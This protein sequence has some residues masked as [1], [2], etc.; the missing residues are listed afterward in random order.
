MKIKNI[1]I[2]L[3]LVLLPLF[4]AAQKPV[5][6]SLNWIEPV[7][8]YFGADSAMQSLAFE[9]AQYTGLP[10]EILPFSVTITDVP[11]GM[12]V[13]D[14]RFDN[15]TYIPISDEERKV[16]GEKELLSAPYLNYEVLSERGNL[17]AIAT[18]LPFG[19]NPASGKT[20]KLAS[21]S[22]EIT[23]AASPPVLKSVNTYADNS[24]L[25]TGDWYKFYLAESGVYKITF[26]DLKNLGI[27]TNGLN[28]DKI[29]IFGNGG[30]ML[31]M[32]AGVITADDLHENSISVFTATPG[33]F[34]QGDYILFYGKGPQTWIRNPLSGRLD[35]TTHLYADEACYFLTIGAENG[36]RI[37]FTE[38]P[39]NPADYFVNEYTALFHYEKDLYNLIKSG[40]KWFG[41][42][43]DFYNRTLNIPQVTF[44]DI[45]PGSNAVIRYGI[46]GRST[47]NALSFNFLVNNQVVGTSTLAKITSKYDYAFD[48]ITSA[49]FTPPAD[50]LDIQFKFNPL[51]S[52]DL[53]WLDFI[54]L[55]VQCSLKFTGG[56]MSFRD[57]KSIA[58]NR[59][60]EFS[61]SNA[62]TVTEIW[63]VTDP[64]NVFLV[65]YT[66]SGD[67]VKFNSNTTVL[68]E[69][70]ALNGTSYN[71]IRPGEKISNQNLHS[72]G[73]YDLIVITHP[74]FSSQAQ[75]LAT[76]HNDM[77]EISAIVVSLPEIYNEFSSGIQDITAIRNFM[78]MLYD[79]GRDAGYPK[80]LLLF[81]NASYD[82]KNRIP[83]N[84]NF[85][86]SFQSDNS[87]KTTASFLSDDYY[88]LLDDGEGGSNAAGMLDVA[89]GRMPV[90]TQQEAN[91]V[92][93][94]TI[95]YMANDA[96]VHGDWRNTLI[97][98]ADDEDR[99]AHLNQAEGLTDSILRNHPV[100]NTEKIYFDA[101]KQVSTPGGSRY[102]DVNRE[103]VSKVEKGALVVNYIG[104]GGEVG[105]ADERILEIAD[106]N[107]WTN[108]SRMGLFFTA[109]CEFSRFD[110]PGHTSAGELVFLNPDGGAM[111]MITTTRLAFSSNNAA[112]NLSFADTAFKSTGGNIP[113]LGDILKYTKN[114][115]G[116]GANTRHLTLFG[117][118]SIRM[119][120]P[121][122]KVITTSIND[123][124][125]GLP[126]D[127]LFATSLVKVTGEVRDAENILLTGFNGE[128]Q[129]KVLDKPSKVRTLGQD[130]LSLQTEFYVQKSILYQ[131]KASVVNGLFEFTFPVPKDIDYSFGRGKLSYYV[132]DGT[133]DG[134]G[135]SKDFTIG[136]S[137]NQPQLD[138]TGP[139]IK[140]FMNDTNFI[141]GSITNESPKLL[142]YL[143]DESGINTV[144]NGIGHDIVATINGNNY[145]S[146]VLNDY[147]IADLNS[148]QS[149]SL[150]YQYFNLPDGEHILTLKAWDV[151]NNSSEASIR[152]EVKRNIILSLDEVLAYPNPTKGP[153][154]FRFGHNQYDGRFDVDVEIYS[155]TGSLVRSL[156]PFKVLSE[157]YQSGIVS[158]DGRLDD[159]SLARG[160]LYVARLKVR[161]RNGNTTSNTAKV[162]VAR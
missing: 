111:S 34:A 32:T 53:G 126:A 94:K 57:S 65:N 87:I 20:E 99:N 155:S 37:T 11:A 49:T 98:L 145:N 138:F 8:L 85:V 102:P 43:M 26:D 71:S 157:G 79:R 136:G 9:K 22:L 13:E 103:L 117:D 105:W 146:I 113:R 72:I 119:P 14:I 133:V 159:G 106:I 24:V 150:L 124:K 143:F 130:P 109:T 120:L 70:I 97:V 1:L 46:A 73:N 154:S 6:V 78:K 2:Y 121:K 38:P 140:L 131:G 17:K 142:A 52:T 58:N 92:V 10:D 96:P 115:N 55:N 69:F 74:D 4:V 128:V 132:T 61:L 40:R 91:T 100:Y 54:T 48:L 93:E 27:N 89:V 82:V 147:Y 64:L 41:E 63:D 144:G 12:H 86:P 80:Y 139:E 18:V 21:Y 137:S 122:H 95:T 23:F 141:E 160:G 19:L 45:I 67:V 104:H 76:A 44:S 81:G 156:G 3:V 107:S 84:S 158:W 162:I 108:Y 75:T 50:M 83:Q 114:Q 29:R 149:G 129:I 51:S 56:Q 152:F 39:Q 68:K 16:L 33:V 7:T 110:N 135:F 123:A 101:F 148:Y 161:D 77:G 90:R 88:V 66:R 28:P 36:R 134:H 25:A 112:L 42:K 62:N 5:N 153:I 116:S 15:L 31:N 35:H 151:F 60:S 125:T 30:A 118:P 47:T 59:I 127:T